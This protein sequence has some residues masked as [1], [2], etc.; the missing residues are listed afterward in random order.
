MVPNRNVDREILKI[1][2]IFTKSCKCTVEHLIAKFVLIIALRLEILCGI[3][4]L[5][6][7]LFSI[8]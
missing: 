8:D 3:V 4:E 1:G 2:R 6:D 7:V 5:L